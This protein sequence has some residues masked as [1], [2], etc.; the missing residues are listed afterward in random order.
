MKKTNPC[1]R[2]VFLLITL[3]LS[4]YSFSR[5]SFQFKIGNEIYVLSD[6][7]YRKTRENFFEAIGN[8]VITHERSSLYGEKATISLKNG[9]MEVVGNVRY[10]DPQ[11]TLYGSELYY[12]FKTSFIS[13]K[14]AKVNA[15]NYVVL[16]RKMTRISKDVITAEDAEY[17][18]CLDCPES[19]SVFGKKVR[20][21]IGRYIR[22][23]H[24]FI[25][26]NGVV[27]MYVPYMVLPIKKERET[28]LLFPRINY[29]IGDGVTYQQPWFWAIN[30]Y[31]DMTLVPSVFGDK[32]IGNELEYRHIFGESKWFEINSLHVNDRVYMPYKL[33][34]NPSGKKYFRHFSEYEHHFSFGH[35]ANHHFYFNDAKELDVVR[36][37]NDYIG[38][39]VHGS[40]LGAEGFIELRSSM[41]NFEVEGYSN[42]NMLVDDPI[43]RDASYVQILP[44]LSFSTSPVTLLHTSIP[45]LQ[46]ISVSGL[47]DY[48]VFRQNRRIEGEFIRNAHRLNVNPFVDWRLYNF[49]P[50][51]LSTRLDMD[52]QH[53]RFPYER[54]KTF[55]KK[56]YV[57]ETELG[58]EIER[59]W[60]LAYSEMLPP[61]RLDLKN[62]D[63][64][65]KTDIKPGK[66]NLIGEMPTFQNQ[67]ADDHVKIDRHSYRHSQEFKLKHFYLVDQ[68]IS[69][70]SRFKNQITE[71]EGL[72]D[73]LDAIREKEHEFAYISS[74]ASLPVGNTIELQWNNTFMKKSPRK[75][76]SF[77]DGRY[78]RQNF[79][80]SKVAWFNLSQGYDFNINSDE[81]DDHLTRLLVTTGFNILRTSISVS[82]HYYYL[83]NGHL[84]NMT[85]SQGFGYGRIGAGFNY[86]SFSLPVNKKFYL[87]G[88]I[89]PLDIIS[90]T[91]KNDFDLVSRELSGSMYGILYRPRNNC[92]KVR[93][94]YKKTLVDTTYSLKFV[95]NYNEK[96]FKS[97]D[98]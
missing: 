61:S 92:W 69:G 73:S 74:R 71:D 95:V 34:D 83:T 89:D 72:F 38:E 80:Y 85:M 94:E 52:Y 27:S 45:G 41:M 46:N 18:T 20:I 4:E 15:G 30:P 40:E 26:I 2:T 33:D 8:V 58:A 12:N 97:V 87:L 59:I 11:I 90:L 86:Y 22:I 3:V 75:F 63:R 7:A 36:D 5:E 82:E 39:R 35:Y 53:Y 9:D 78:L 29:R 51:A 81:F 13:I 10:V 16:G 14:N 98:N 96:S 23:W 93:L 65:K 32:G 50:V 1:L 66:G 6:K 28:G 88:Q 64:D 56:G 43:K 77:V 49:G 84:F 24:A 62:F 57:V 25:K 79:S 76:N 37:Y 48:T 91:F 42:K 54:E 17:T 67:F 55:T 70:N 47:G 60:G 44:K 21:T 19:W 31:A 68:E